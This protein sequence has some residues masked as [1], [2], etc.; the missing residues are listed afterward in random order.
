MET[1]EVLS[2]PG[3]I[4]GEDWPHNCGL[5]KRAEGKQ[6]GGVARRSDEVW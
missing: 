6:D 4:P 1:G 3:E 5:R 2:A